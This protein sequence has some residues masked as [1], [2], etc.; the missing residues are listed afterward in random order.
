MIIFSDTLEAIYRLGQHIIYQAPFGIM[1]IEILY[2]K[3]S[4]IHKFTT[5]NKI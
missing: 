4:L 3:I 1:D 5:I 2:M